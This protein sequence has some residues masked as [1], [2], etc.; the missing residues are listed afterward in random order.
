MKTDVNNY[1]EDIIESVKQV[2]R[3]MKGITRS[4][5][6]KN[7]KDQD[8]LCRRLEIIGEAANRIPKDTQKKMPNVPWKEI[9][10]MRNKLIHDYGEVD[11][12]I[13]WQTISDDI[14]ILKE[15]ILSY[16]DSNF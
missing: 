5:F 9:V 3:H 14:P 2:E 1:L 8:A 10:G 7:I 11:A 15:N 6:L 13:L 16:L 12:I 4:R